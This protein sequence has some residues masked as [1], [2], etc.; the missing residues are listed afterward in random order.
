M[1]FKHLFIAGLSAAI[2]LFQA[3]TVSTSNDELDNPNDT[4][5][6][7]DEEFNALPISIKELISTNFLLSVLYVNAATELK[8]LESY[9]MQGPENGFSE[10]DYE[11][12]DV[13]YMY[14]TLS[15]NF[16]NYFSPYIADRILSRLLY[17]EQQAGIGADFLEI[18]GTS[19][20][21]EGVCN[22]SNTLVFKHVYPNGPAE[23]AGIQKGDTLYTING[24]VPRN[25]AQ[26]NRI[27]GVFDAGENVPITV[28]RGEEIIAFTVTFDTYYVPTVFVDEIDSIPVITVTEFT[29]TT[30]TN[31]G[32][33]GEFL[34]ALEETKGAKSTIID[35]RGNP[36]G[37]TGQC[38]NMAAELL[39]K[40]DTVITIIGHEIDTTFYTGY[41]DT[42]TYIAEEDGIGAGRYYVI[43][44]DSG[45][46][47]CAELMIVGVVSNTKSPIVG[48]VTYGKGIG[49]TYMVTYAD[50]ITGITSMRLLDKNK[51]TYHR[52]GIVPDF[53]EADSDKALQKAVELAKEGTVER[54]QGYGTVDTGH[55]TLAKR[56]GKKEIDRGMF[57]VIRN[58]KK[59]EK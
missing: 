24:M 40:N 43:L 42:T 3:C 58:P 51:E 7:S 23:K 54:T 38:I 21:Q 59:I 48:Q 31:E 17:S 57:K 12:P 39:P 46:A 16:T 37:S 4:G 33:Y 9:Y 14:S 35:L 32:T 34:A 22:D 45:S 26:Y 11:F 56:Q 2:L 41:I 8:D 28:K 52:Y 5:E 15:D 25:E 18:H 44:A 30:Y 20:I 29:D 55:F 49:Q 47:S 50:G 6:M 53:E 27:E 19:C 1:K 13:S 36:G 10:D